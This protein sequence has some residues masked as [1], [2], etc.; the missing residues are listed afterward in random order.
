MLVVVVMLVVG[1]MLAMTVVMVAVGMIGGGRD[2]G[3]GREPRAHGA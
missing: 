2:H 1:V 3:Y